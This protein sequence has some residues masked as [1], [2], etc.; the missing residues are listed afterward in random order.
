MSKVKRFILAALMISLVTSMSA[1]MRMQP[2][3]D[4]DDDEDRDARTAKKEEDEDDEVP[5]EEKSDA[6]SGATLETGDEP[7]IKV[8]APHPQNETTEPTAEATTPE[9]Q[10]ATSEPAVSVAPDSVGD[11]RVTVLTFTNELEKIIENYARADLP[12]LNIEFTL[13]PSDTYQS[14]LKVMLA[15]G[16]DSMDVFTLESAY[17]KS[18]LETGWLLDL[19]DMLPMA[20]EAG[21]PQY[22]IDMGR[23]SGGKVRAYTWQC[24]PG[25]FF[26]RRSLAKQYLG[27]DDP[28]KVQGM[29]K[30]TASFLSTARK[31][32]DNSGGIVKICTTGDLFN[33]FKAGRKQ[34][35]VVDGRLVIDQNMLDLANL[36]K[37]LK[38][39][40]LDNGAY[41]WDSMWFNGMSDS[42]TDQNGNTIYTFGYFLP[43][44][45]L[46]YVLIPNSTPMGGYSSKSTDGDWA[47]CQGPFPYFWGGTW[48]AAS[49]SA[50]DY[51]AKEFIAYC[52]M[53]EN[54]QYDYATWGAEP[55][56][57]N[58]F[59]SSMNVIDRLKASCSQPFLGGQNHF[60]QFA[61]VAKGINAATWTSYDQEIDQLWQ[62]HTAL[63]VNGTRT[64]EQA[65]SAFKDEVKNRFPELSV[66]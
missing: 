11:G 40:K 14:K 21:L 64:L 35:W 56:T 31:L 60:E 62:N 52:T 29:V 43:T 16:D 22:T 50:R 7:T 57:P 15:S 30:D 19:T 24:N 41:C 55:S 38:D 33:P 6:V 51:E 17:M 46:D 10:A 26:Y 53:N 23:D 39:G 48:L 27:T 49:S 8:A 25:A 61:T 45:G 2:R 28:A 12:H 37:T 5:D 3:D 66:K 63:Y 34:G 32:S 1:C 44:W 47:M 20:Q 59:V 36:Q 9:P 65:V 4:W 58:E 18:F 54:F 13:V 42:A